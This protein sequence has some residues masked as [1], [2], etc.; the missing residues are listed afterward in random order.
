MRPIDADEV[1]RIR[2]EQCYDCESLEPCF[3]C[4]IKRTPTLDVVPV[5]RCKD[6]KFSEEKHFLGDTCLYCKQFC[7]FMEE[8]GFCYRAKRKDGGQNE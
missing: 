7:Y 4:V 2:D 5:V 3:D 1:F 8:S 6:C